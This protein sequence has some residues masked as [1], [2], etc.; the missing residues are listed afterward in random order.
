MLPASLAQE[1]R[2]SRGERDSYTSRREAS[3]L[4][5]KNFSAM[6]TANA[7]PETTNLYVGNLPPNVSEESL[8][9]R[10]SVYGPIQV[11]ARHSASGRGLCARSEMGGHLS[12]LRPVEGRRRSGREPPSRER[13]SHSAS[14][15]RPASASTRRQSVKIM[16]PRTEEEHARNRLCGFVAFVGR[17]DADKA[18]NELNETDFNGHVMRIGWG[19]KVAQVTP[20]LTLASFSAMG[21]AAGASHLAAFR[22]PAG[23]GAG[24]AIAAVGE[25]HR[26]AAVGATAAVAAVP[27]ACSPALGPSAAGGGAPATALDGGAGVGAPPA[28]VPIQAPAEASRAVID[29]LALYVAEEGHAFE[30]VLLAT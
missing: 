24:A 5:A 18:R 20:A 15:R 14:S 12:S 23:A 25:Q 19:K 22:P 6:E 30:Q 10:F 3:D 21:A 28:A 17:S 2:E 27:P 8:F 9:Q 13:P 7:D 29:R 16:W 4:G 11:Y 1:E 26:A